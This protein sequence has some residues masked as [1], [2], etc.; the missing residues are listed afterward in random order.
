MLARGVPIN[1]I[2]L[3]AHWS[4]S[5]PSREELENSIRLF[6]SLGLQVQI[7]ELDISV[8][9]GKQGGQMIRSS[10]SDSTAGFTSEM[11]QQQLEKY[12]MA[13]EVFRKYRKQIT[14][15]TF[16]NVSD[17]H[18]WLDGRGKKNFPLLFD[19]DLQP[20]KA[21]SAVVDF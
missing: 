12:K 8:Y 19:K 10:D 13:F 6:S 7:T 17:R 21:Y 20:K 5:A 11:E 2:G 3:Q 18:S 4:V 9:P 16:W 15:V 14:G 1:G